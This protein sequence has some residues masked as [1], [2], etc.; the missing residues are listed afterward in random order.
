MIYLVLIIRKFHADNLDSLKRAIEELKKESDKTAKSIKKIK[1]GRTTLTY[2]LMDIT[3][4]KEEQ[5]SVSGDI[6]F[7]DTRISNYEKA[8]KMV[9][10]T[11]KKH[12]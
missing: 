10:N 2:K 6:S 12:L 7:I 8:L 5:C 1:D 9:N 3:L 4:S 11:L